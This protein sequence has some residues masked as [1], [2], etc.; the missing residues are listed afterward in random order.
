MCMDG[1]ANVMQNGVQLFSHYKVNWGAQYVIFTTT[2]SPVYQCIIK[3]RNNFT[4]LYV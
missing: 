1:E 3:K 2:F 4:I